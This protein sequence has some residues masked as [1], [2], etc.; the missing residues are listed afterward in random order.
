VR[1]I[2][3]F[4]VQILMFLFMS[5]SSYST[6]IETPNDQR[7]TAS[8]P[9]ITAT[10]TLPDSYIDLKY[11]PLPSSILTSASWQSGLWNSSSSQFWSVDAVMDEKNIMLWLSRRISYNESGHAI[12]Q[13]RDTVF[14]PPSAR[15]KKI[16][17]SEC[18][19][20]GEPDYEIVALV[21]LD[22]E[23]LENRWL[24]NSH[25]LSAWRANRTKEKLEPISTA[26]IECNAET[27]VSFP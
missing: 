6:P 5:C 13:V 1:G 14:L 22:Q 11:P 12:F 15:D 17:V 25:I 18:V 8:L 10:A 26:D 4:L 3:Y 19:L 2:R 7:A 21:K 24:P 20:D 27:F 23:S 9:S 16:I